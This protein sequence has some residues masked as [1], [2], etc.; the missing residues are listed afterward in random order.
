MSLDL[1]IALWI[2]D[3]GEDESITHLLIVKE[4][5]IFL[6]DLSRYDFASAGAARTSPTGVGK[7]NTSLLS[8]I[9]NV[10]VLATLDGLL[11][12]RSDESNSS[13]HLDVS[14]NIVRSSGGELLVQ[15]SVINWLGG[16]GG[17]GECS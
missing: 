5:L 4:G 15:K 17:N 11:S 2:S 10:G 8:G 9:E 16:S 1:D 3:T 13:H 6:V 7:V 12:I 14:S